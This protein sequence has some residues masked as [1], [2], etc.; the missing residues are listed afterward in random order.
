MAKSGA[1]FKRHEKK[2]LLTKD[3]YNSLLDRL[4]DY[5]EEDRYGVH[6]IFSLYFDT[7]DYLLIRRSIEKPKYKEK[8][9]LRSYGTPTNESKV[10]LELK[11]KYDG[12]TYKRRVSMK[13]YEVKEL[14]ANGSTGRQGQIL[15]EIKWFC[16]QYNNLLPRVLICYERVALYG[17]EDN[18]L[19]ITFDANIRYR[20]DN[21]DP[22]NGSDGTPIIKPSERLMEIKIGSSYPCWLSRILSELNIYPISFSKYG[23]AYKTIKSK[24]EK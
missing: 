2:F 8:L 22:V 6:T 20:T 15:D 1:V 9:R 19:R 23:T 10:F 24:E 11:K 3:Q 21:V 5:M 13:L 17:I 12:I 14:I 18:N 16:Q 7:D 4:E